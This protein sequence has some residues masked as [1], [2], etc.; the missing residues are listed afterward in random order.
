MY[1]VSTLLFAAGLATAPVDS[2]ELRREELMAALRGGGYTV[3]LRHARTDRGFKEAMGEVPK[4]RSEQ[5]N[6]SDDG[7]RDA[8]LMG[9]VFR[10]HGVTFGE[11]ISSPM[12]RAMETAEMASG[13]PSITMA[14]RVYPA[15]PEQALLVKTAPKRGNNRLLVTHHFVIETHVPG[16]RPGDIGE[17]EA[18]V[19]RHLADGNIELAGRISLDDWGALANPSQP[20]THGT[21]AASGAKPATSQTMATAASHHQAPSSTLPKAGAD[22]P[23]TPIGR[24]A[25]E[26]VAAFNTGAAEKMRTFIESL[27]VK[28]SARPTDERVKSYAKLF[29]DHGSLTV[30][31]VDSSVATHVTL[32]MSSKRGEFRLTVKSADAQPGRVASVTFAMREGAHP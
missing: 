32:V 3:V 4:L 18:A 15:T 14:L 8:A 26:Y 6:L 25:R 13:K 27:M 24:L 5:R 7:N 16:I 17:S 2:A 22:I 23:D 30:S 9:V 12:A 31:S 11:V 21:A 1:L 29:E 28:D 10:K 20:A 19:V